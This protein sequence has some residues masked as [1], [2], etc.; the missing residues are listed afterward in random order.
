[1]TLEEF[2]AALPALTQQFVWF[3]DELG[4]LRAHDVRMGADVDAVEHSTITA[5]AE[6]RT[7]VVYCC[8][9]EFDKAAE[10]LGLSLEDAMEITSA[11][12]LDSKHVP[13]LA[14]KLREA[15]GVQP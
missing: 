4:Q 12:D 3:E 10:A 6:V 1:M 8:M 5:L 15:V 9:R 7:G 11:E 2:L 13:L 14:K